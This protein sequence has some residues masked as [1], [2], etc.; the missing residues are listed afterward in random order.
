MT[1]TLA[2]NKKRLKARVGRRTA[3]NQTFRQLA[4][5]FV[6]STDPAELEL[7]KREMVRRV[8]RRVPGE[9]MPPHA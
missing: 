4:Y 2:D 6:R 3:A 1:R 7:L 9:I 8:A 5:R